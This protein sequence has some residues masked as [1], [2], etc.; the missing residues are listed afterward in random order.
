MPEI[1]KVI[2]LSAFFYRFGI[3]WKYRFHVWGKMEKNAM[4]TLKVSLMCRITVERGETAI[5]YC[6]IKEN[7]YNLSNVLGPSSV[8][9]Q[10]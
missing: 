3:L 1:F 5:A 9:L 7:P 4:A 2:F 10:A 8:N 6:S